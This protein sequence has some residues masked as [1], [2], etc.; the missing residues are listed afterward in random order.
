MWCRTL[1]FTLTSHARRIHD[2]KTPLERVERDIAWLKRL[3]GIMMPGVQP[4][5]ILH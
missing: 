2:P 4:K 5:G 3:P 1:W